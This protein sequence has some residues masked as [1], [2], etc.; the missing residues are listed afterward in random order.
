MQPGEFWSLPEVPWI[1]SSPRASSQGKLSTR[2]WAKL[3]E[4]MSP[5]SNGL[6]VLVVIVQ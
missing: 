3:G 1:L 4:P 6:G 2:T 5:F